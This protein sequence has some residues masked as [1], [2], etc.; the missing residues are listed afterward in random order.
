[1]GGLICWLVLSVQAA[2]VCKLFEALRSILRYAFLFLISLL[3]MY[4]YECIYI[5][6]CKD[7]DIHLFM[8]KDCTHSSFTSHPTFRR[9]VR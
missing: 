8:S 4:K 2:M 6:K 7:E 1:M 9:H 5:Y 3:D